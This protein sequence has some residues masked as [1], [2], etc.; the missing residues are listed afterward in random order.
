[1]H[2]ISNPEIEEWRVLMEVRA[3]EAEKAA[4]R[5]PTDTRTFED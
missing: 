5:K 1:M 2:S 3:E 4:K